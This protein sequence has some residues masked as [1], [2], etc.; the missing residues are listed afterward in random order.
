MKKPKYDI[1]R[2]LC[3]AAEI[4][5]KFRTKVFE[6]IIDNTIRYVAPSYGVDVPLVVRHCL[7]GQL[8][9]FIVESLLSIILLWTFLSA[10][11]SHGVIFG[12]PSFVIS[13]VTYPLLISFLLRWLNLFIGYRVVVKDLKHIDIQAEKRS[14]VESQYEKRIMELETLQDGNVVYYSGYTPFVGAGIRMAGW[15]FVCST[16]T[17]EGERSEQSVI[18]LPALYNHVNKN[19]NSLHIPHLNVKD[20]LYVNGREIREDDRFLT[21]PYQAPIAQI[22]ASLID[23]YKENQE[24]N[25]RYYQTVQVVGW[26]G[27]LVLSSFFRVSKNDKHLF[28]EANYYVLPPLEP[29]FYEIDQLNSSIPL[30]RILKMGLSSIIPSIFLLPLA[31]SRAIRNG[32]AFWSS[33]KEKKELLKQISKNQRF[34]YGAYES[35]REMAASDELQNFFQ[36]S[37]L[38]MYKKQIERCF[39]D[40]VMEY[41]EGQNVDISEFIKRKE[42]VINQGIMINGG[43]FSAE[44]VSVG[45]QTNTIVNQVKSTFQ[46][47]NSVSV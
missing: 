23:E 41:L 17:K 7:R 24:E 6:Q 33:W 18:S 26:Q 31:P 45:N 32:A 15:S 19:M 11:I 21:D 12:I 47:N 9:D 5:P 46:N 27:N 40:S 38:E 10:I 39:T 29:G 1:T 4:S 25:V 13:L 16:A 14:F 22:A 43:S 44:N 20:M 3:A 42:T 30:G 36:K 37:D 2:Y 34:D 8:R 35:I 28:V